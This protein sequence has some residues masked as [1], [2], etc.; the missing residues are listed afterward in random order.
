M[1]HLKAPALPLFSSPAS[2]RL[3]WVS[4]TPAWIY[5]HESTD[6]QICTDSRRLAAKVLSM[7][8]VIKLVCC[9]CRAQTAALWVEELR[10]RFF[11]RI[12]KYEN[13]GITAGFGITLRQIVKKLFH[14]LPYKSS[15]LT[16]HI[17]LIIITNI[18]ENTS[19]IVYL[20]LFINRNIDAVLLKP[21]TNKS[22]VYRNW[23]ITVR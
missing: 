14:L 13:W 18:T 16:A 19:P 22:A 2:R 5:Q 23:K 10:G 20:F 6:T 11:Y 21:C 4:L 7:K 12:K 15:R 3:L 17:F 9:Y 8:A 1:H